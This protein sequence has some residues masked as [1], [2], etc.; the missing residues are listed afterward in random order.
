MGDPMVTAYQKGSHP[1]PIGAAHCRMLSGLPSG[2]V[3]GPTSWRR[4][5]SP[6]SK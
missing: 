6:A 5:P 3:V 1:A 2:L 4:W